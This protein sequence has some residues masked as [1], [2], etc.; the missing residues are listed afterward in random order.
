MKVMFIRSNPVALY[1]RSRKTARHGTEGTVY[2]ELS[3][4]M[5]Y[6]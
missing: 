2:N 4:R 6:E 5:D 3:R 1:P